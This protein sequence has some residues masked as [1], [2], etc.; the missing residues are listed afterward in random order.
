MAITKEIAAHYAR[1]SYFT[2]GG[3][4]LSGWVKLRDSNQDNLGADGYFGV[5]YV[6]IDSATNKATEL[7]IAHRGTEPT[8]LQDLL[9]D[10]QLALSELPN[11]QVDDAIA[12]KNSVLTEFATK[13]YALEVTAEDITTNVGHSLGGYLAIHVADDMGVNG[14]AKVF[15]NPATTLGNT[16]A[17]IENYLNHSNHINRAGGD[18]LGDVYRIQTRDFQFS[19]N[20]EAKVINSLVAV[21]DTALMLVNGPAEFLDTLSGGLTGNITDWALLPT[22]AANTIQEHSI[23]SIIQRLGSATLESI[24]HN[25]SALESYLI[26]DYSSTGILGGIVNE[27]W[28]SDFDEYGFTKAGFGNAI[29][30]VLNDPNYNSA[31]N[32]TYFVSGSDGNNTLVG[33][34]DG[35]VLLS[36]DGNDVIDLSEGQHILDAGD[37]SDT[38]SYESL[39]N[40]EGINVDLGASNSYIGE[41][42]GSP[43]DIFTNVENVVGSS[44]GDQILGNQYENNLQGNGGNDELD[45][46]LGIDDA[47]YSGDYTKDG[48]GVETGYAIESLGNETYRITDTD[49]TDGDDGV[50]TLV[51]VEYAQFANQRIK[52]S[53]ED[54]DDE[55]GGGGGG[56]TTDT[57][58]DDGGSFSFTSDGFLGDDGLLGFGFGVT[59]GLNATDA[60]EHN[61]VIILDQSYSLSAQEFASAQAS[62]VN[63]ISTAAA[64][65]GL[66][67]SNGDFVDNPDAPAV[68]FAV[69]PFAEV[70]T[71]SGNLTPAQ[72]ISHI[73]GLGQK[74][75]TKIDPPLNTAASY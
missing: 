11:D 65:L 56:S 6:K 15:D 29:V 22:S 32:T 31:A 68:S 42:S 70:A 60:L 62:A 63:Y 45:G 27:Y 36:Q 67:D 8:D 21:V 20:D 25:T 50:D 57:G 72:A 37:G 14:R 49:T 39:T 48:S 28:N 38:I 12:F 9:A 23:D 26:G 55:G 24:D 58:T 61:Y 33:G 10:G 46:G 47:L 64:K 7:V 16:N 43:K 2:D 44:F 1:E 4:P 30:S 34:A 52:L 69:V 53:G 71:L 66:V 19:S 35:D 73:N 40:P 51:N 41:V 13:S 5:A 75:G 18:H 74:D 3:S 54:D 17:D 59:N